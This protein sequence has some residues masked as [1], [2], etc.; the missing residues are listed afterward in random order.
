MKLVM[1]QSDAYQTRPL[2]LIS[3]SP[4]HPSLT[5][6]VFFFPLQVWG[7]VR[8][9]TGI[10]DVSHSNGGDGALTLGA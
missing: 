3:L 9:A 2:T 1:F 6:D 8:H 4:G 10:Y 7:Q 5:H